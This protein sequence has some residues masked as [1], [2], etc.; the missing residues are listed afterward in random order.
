MTEWAVVSF[1]ALSTVSDAVF[2]VI[3]ACGTV[4]DKKC[5]LKRL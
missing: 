1:E 3:I 4:N 5:R 2:L